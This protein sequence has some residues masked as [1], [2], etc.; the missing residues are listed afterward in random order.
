MFLMNGTSR[1]HE[2]GAKFRKR[3][4]RKESS[5][6]PKGLCADDEERMRVPKNLSQDALAESER[7]ENER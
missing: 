3:K 5:E 4:V 2:E 7:R 6:E 1:S